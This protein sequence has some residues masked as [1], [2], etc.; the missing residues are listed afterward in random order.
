MESSLAAGPLSQGLAAGVSVTVEASSRN[1]HDWGRALAC[2][3]S[4]LVEQILQSTGTDPCRGATGL[5]LT[6][7]ITER[8][9]GEAITVTWQPSATETIGREPPRS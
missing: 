1:P 4:G 5:A 3:V 7:H 9:G 2:A 6:L 8:P